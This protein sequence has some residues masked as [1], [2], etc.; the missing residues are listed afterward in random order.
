MRGFP[1]CL[2]NNDCE[3]SKLS[4]TSS[5]YLWWW[6]VVGGGE[7]KC[8]GKLILLLIKGIHLLEGGDP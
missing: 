1:I 2:L 3:R 6:V 8:M 4:C 7:R 5:N